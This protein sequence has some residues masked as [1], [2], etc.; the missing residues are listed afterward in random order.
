MA[1]LGDTALVPAS[2]LAR[3]LR[4]DGLSAEISYEQMKLT[5]AMRIASK[6]GAQF[7]VIIGEGEL[8]SGR[9]QVKDMSTGG[10]EEVESAR[11]ALYLKD[12]IQ[13]SGARIQHYETLTPG[14]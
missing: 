7:T 14:S 5:K 2:A 12:K 1:W 4:R 10:Q 11:I 6:L 8:A 3:E 13:D 9:Y